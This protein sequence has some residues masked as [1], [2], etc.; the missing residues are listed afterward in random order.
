[1]SSMICTTSKLCA[2]Q[3]GGDALCRHFSKDLV[4]DIIRNGSET[5]A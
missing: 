2:I 1:M 3:K 4:D 5:N